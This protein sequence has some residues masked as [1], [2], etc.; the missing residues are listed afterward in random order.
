MFLR[1]WGVGRRGERLG[2]VAWNFATNHGQLDWL[3]GVKREEGV[4]QG[5]IVCGGDC[6]LASESCILV[7]VH[8]ADHE[9]PPTTEEHPQDVNDAWL[10]LAN[11]ELR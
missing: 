5:I 11:R 2:D 10:T 8:S 9:P 7:C 1:S 4:C 3:Q 6:A